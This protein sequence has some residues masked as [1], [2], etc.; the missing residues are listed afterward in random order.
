LSPH[1]NK[2]YL[3]AWNTL[4]LGCRQKQPLWSGGMLMGVGVDD[5]G[6]SASLECN[7]LR[8]NHA[9]ATPDSSQNPPKM[10]L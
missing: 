1:A 7:F 5:F 9:Q 2:E 4:A 8:E 3:S 10:L 6:F